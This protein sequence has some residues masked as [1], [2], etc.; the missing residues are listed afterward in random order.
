MI[1]GYCFLLIFTL[2][3]SMF[4]LPKMGEEDTLLQEAIQAYQ[5][6]D[7]G[8]A[9]RFFDE[10]LQR[11]P[12]HEQALEGAGL[13]RYQAMEYLAAQALFERLYDRHGGVYAL[14]M[15]GNCALQQYKPFKA[16]VYYA[17]GLALDPA[18]ETLKR[19]LLLAEDGITRAR[20]LSYLYHRAA[21]I[22]Q[23]IVALAV[24][25]LASIV[26]VEIRSAHRKAY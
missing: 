6:G 12:L 4:G 21:I 5:E 23:G 1:I 13:I 26:A 17:E 2:V 8:K 25:L 18:N 19:N 16:R 10:L 15:L 14:L 9:L 3:N 22:Y 11:N 7:S 20:E 24:L